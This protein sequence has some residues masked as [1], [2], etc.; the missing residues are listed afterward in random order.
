VTWAVARADW[1]DPAIGV[2]VGVVD[3][4]I[5]EVD[6]F[7]GGRAGSVTATPSGARLRIAATPCHPLGSPPRTPAT[8][9]IAA[10]DRRAFSRCGNQ[11][12]VTDA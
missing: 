5:V 1:L 6:V 7:G 2:A 12:V 4:G 3:V 10:F 9:S 11:R 8:P